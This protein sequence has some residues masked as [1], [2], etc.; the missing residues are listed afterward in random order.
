M[1]KRHNSQGF[2]A[3]LALLALDDS[4]NFVANA[5]EET[6]N[7]G[8]LLTALLLLGLL[9]LA[10][11]LLNGGGGGG[12][13]LLILLSLSLLS[14]CISSGHSGCGGSASRER[15]TIGASAVDTSHELLAG[16]RVHVD[17]NDCDDS[18]VVVVGGN[19][20]DVEVG[21]RCVLVYLESEECNADSVSDRL[22]GEVDCVFELGV[23]DS[24]RGAAGF[25]AVDGQ[26]HVRHGCFY[27]WSAAVFC[28]VVR[29]A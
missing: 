9:L 25:E 19:D 24:R 20:G 10:I 14:S 17:S 28:L 6:A 22:I 18:Q 5:A 16:R 2:L 26:G 11:D 4:S 3:S 8:L 15:T 29:A 7:K 13:G 21:A 27:S 1:T 12:E 23:L